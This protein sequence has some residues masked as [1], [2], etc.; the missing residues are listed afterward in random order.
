MDR[1]GRGEIAGNS[2]TDVASVQVGDVITKV[3]P[4]PDGLFRITGQKSYSTGSILANWIDTYAELTDTGE[5]VI[6][7]RASSLDVAGFGECIRQ[8]FV[9]AEAVNL[10]L[11]RRVCG[12]FD[13]RKHFPQLNKIPPPID[14]HLPQRKTIS[15]YGARHPMSFNTLSETAPDDLSPPDA[16][17]TPGTKHKAFH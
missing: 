6:A 2:W 17:R 14:S 8:L 16:L 15:N 10:A 13:Y 11:A 7:R 12:Q 5:R 4:Q 1:F 9:N 3:T